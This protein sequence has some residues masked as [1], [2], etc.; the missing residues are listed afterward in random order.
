MVLGH[1]NGAR[2]MNVRNA[3]GTTLTVRGQRRAEKVSKRTGGQTKVVA[4]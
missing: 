2:W 4:L 3:D 1:R